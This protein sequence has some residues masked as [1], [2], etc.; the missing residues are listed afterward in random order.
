MDTTVNGIPSPWRQSLRRAG[1]ERVYVA[2]FETGS[3][4]YLKGG[5][6]FGKI[7]DVSFQRKAINDQD[8]LVPNII[9]LDTGSDVFIPISGLDVIVKEG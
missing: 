7:Y 3:E 4:V 6:V 9:Y 5:E 1:I 8:L 2:D